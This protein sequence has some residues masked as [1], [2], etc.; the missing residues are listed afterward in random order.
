MRKI[1]L[2]VPM[3]LGLQSYFL[4]GFYPLLREQIPDVHLEPVFIQGPAINFARNN[5]AH[6]AL[7]R[8]FDELVMADDDLIWSVKEFLRLISHDVD[9]V[10]SV[11]T[12]R[13]PGA[14]HWLFVPRPGAVTQPNGLIE[15]TAVATG[16]IRFKTRVFKTILETMPERGFACKE[17]PQDPISHRCDFFPM[18]PVGP[19]TYEARFERIKVI[20]KRDDATIDDIRTAAFDEQPPNRL[21][22]EDWGACRLARQAGFKVWTDLGGDIFPHV[23]HIGFPITPEMVGWGPGI[24]QIMPDPDDF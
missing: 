21:V 17:S 13:K 16:L 24:S 8:G 9:V 3:K 18:S 11:Y 2:G 7:S 23:G 12:K 14:P 15:S 6:E 1:M 22:G 20:L 5:F 4:D 10:G 19:R